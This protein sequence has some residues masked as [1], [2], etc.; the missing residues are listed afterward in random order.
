LGEDSGL[1]PSAL[2]AVNQTAAAHSAAE[3]RDIK[4]EERPKGRKQAVTAFSYSLP[5]LH[6]LSGCLPSISSLS[7]TASSTTMSPLAS[8]ARIE[9]FVLNLDLPEKEVVELYKKREQVEKL[10]DSYKTAL[11]ADRLYLQAFVFG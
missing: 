9:F 6:C 7:K 11:S 5:R 4:T 2:W 3:R 1:W 8:L 10:F